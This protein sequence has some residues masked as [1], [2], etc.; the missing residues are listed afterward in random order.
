MSFRVSLDLLDYIDTLT[1]G[2]E[3]EQPEHVTLEVT[4]YERKLNFR[5]QLVV[6]FNNLTTQTVPL[7]ATLVVPAFCVSKSLLDFGTCLV[8]QRRE[9]QFIISN[10]TSSASYW[11]TSV[12]ETP[13]PPP[14]AYSSWRQCPHGFWC[15]SNNNGLSQ[16]CHKYC[17]RAKVVDM[18]GFDVCADAVE[19][20][21][22]R[23][24]VALDQQQDRHQLLLHRQVSRISR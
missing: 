11:V 5:S 10:T 19:R 22:G 21:A 9:L 13:T 2:D 8:G 24:R 12:G 23:A 6:E 7:S 17:C 18:P 16:C 3:S 15:Y 4:P 20:D 1:N 14:R